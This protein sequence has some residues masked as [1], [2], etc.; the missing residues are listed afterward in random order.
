MVALLHFYARISTTVLFWLAF[1]LTR[2]FGAKFGDVLTK[3]IEQG[4][5]NLGT[6]GASVFF[7]AILVVTIF[8]ESKLEKFRNQEAIYELRSEAHNRLMQPTH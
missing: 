5:L 1:V 6:I 4:G 2:P 8:K 7:A 3:P